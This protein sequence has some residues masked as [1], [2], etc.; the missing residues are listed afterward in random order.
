MM[1]DAMIEVIAGARDGKEVQKQARTSLPPKWEPFDHLVEGFDFVRYIYRIKPDPPK[2]RE[3]WVNVYP[4]T[5]IV[6]GFPSADSA[7]AY[8][9]EGRI[10]CVHVREVLP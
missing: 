2:P 8:Q 3:W 4:R 10:A 7:D 1:P 6:S 5:Q 9:Q